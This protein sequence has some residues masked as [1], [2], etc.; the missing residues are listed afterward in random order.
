MGRTLN[1]S[2]KRLAPLEQDGRDVRHD[3]LLR[4]VPRPLLLPLSDS[5]T[6][7]AETRGKGGVS[8]AKAVK[9]RGTGAVLAT[10]GA[11]KHEAKALPQPRRQW[12]H[13]AKAVP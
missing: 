9:T 10:K 13:K 5:A 2:G 3:A 4:G 8:A 12:N 6:K 7:A 11:R 1:V